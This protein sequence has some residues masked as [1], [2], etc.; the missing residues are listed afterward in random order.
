MCVDMQWFT[1]FEVQDLGVQGSHVNVGTCVA[2]IPAAPRGRSSGGA[3]GTDSVV[4]KHGWSAPP[5]FKGFGV[6]MV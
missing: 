4:L 3:Q 2:Q 1:C 5:L 6:L